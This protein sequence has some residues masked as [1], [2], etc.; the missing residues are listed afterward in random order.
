MSLGNYVQLIAYVPQCSITNLLLYSRKILNGRMIS[1]QEIIY[2]GNMMRRN[3]ILVL[4]GLY[5]V[6][7]IVIRSKDFVKKFKRTP[8]LVFN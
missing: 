4:K 3:M 6:Q 5:F 2:S 8:N 7:N 1:N